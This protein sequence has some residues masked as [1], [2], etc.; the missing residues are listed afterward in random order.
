MLDRVTARP[1]ARGLSQFS[2]GTLLTAKTP[3]SWIRA[4]IKVFRLASAIAY[5]GLN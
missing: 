5:F 3:M 1:N 4:N 2:T